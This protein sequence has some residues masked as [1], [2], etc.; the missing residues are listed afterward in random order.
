MALFRRKP[1][2]PD[3]PRNGNSLDDAVMEQ[4][5][6]SGVDFTL[7]RDWVHY[8]YCDSAHDAT[9]LS[10][11]AI[12]AG[13]NVRPTQM[14]NGFIANRADKPVNGQ[15]VPEARQFFEGLAAQVPG[16]EYDGWEAAV[17]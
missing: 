7:N 16:G 11:A 2:L 6:L 10:T 17:S 8:V 14:G 3:Y 9:S 1:K 15:T 4:L 12:A 13:W 5:A